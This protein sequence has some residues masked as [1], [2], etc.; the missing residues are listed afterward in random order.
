MVHSS[1]VSVERRRFLMV[2]LAAVLAISVA[3]CSGSESESIAPAS[4]AKS[5]RLK[6]LEMTK[7]DL[8]KLQSKK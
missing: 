6:R 3:G 2:P 7:D 1:R 5:R 8:K 4:D